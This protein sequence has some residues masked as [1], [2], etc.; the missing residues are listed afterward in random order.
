M[1]NVERCQHCD[2]KIVEYKHNLTPGL[3]SGLIELSK[4]GGGPINLKEL[5]LTRNQ[6][7]N[8]QKMRYWGLVSKVGGDR[9]GVWEITSLGRDFVE[10]RTSCKKSVWTYRGATV[11]T[12]GKDTFIT[13]LNL[14]PYYQ[15]QYEVQAVS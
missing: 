10:G 13:D 14:E 4:A 6:W 3:V 1:S 5:G 11:R 2:A 15:E 8:F 12:D 9:T 7:D